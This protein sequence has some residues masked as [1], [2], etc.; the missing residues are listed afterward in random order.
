MRVR[1]V[2]PE[3]RAGEEVS[4]FISRGACRVGTERVRLIE[5]TARREG[6]KIFFQEDD[7]TEWRFEVLG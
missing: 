7:N 6:D 5:S 4:L 3:A 1:I 2:T